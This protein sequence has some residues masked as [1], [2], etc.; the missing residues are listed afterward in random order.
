MLIRLPVRLALAALVL[1]A[2]AFLLD[3]AEGSVVFN[4]LGYSFSTRPG[5]LLACL[6]AMMLALI[7]IGASLARIRG[8]PQKWRAKRAI[9]TMERLLAAAVQAIAAKA[10]DDPKNF[11]RAAARARWISPKADLTQLLEA[12]R[13]ASR[14]KWKKL[15][16]NRQLSLSAR[17][18]LGNLALANRRV[19]LA[20]DYAEDAGDEDPQWSSSVTAICAA[21]EGDWQAAEAPAKKSK[22]PTLRATISTQRSLNAS[23]D[24]AVEFAKRALAHKADFIPAALRLCQL[25]PADEADRIIAKVW[26]IRPHPSLLRVAS[27]QLTEKLARLHPSNPLSQTAAAL[28]ALSRNEVE[29]AERILAP[30]SDS[31]SAA[32]RA[33]ERVYRQ[34]GKTTK[35]DEIGA[36]TLVANYLKCKKCDAMAAEWQAICRQCGGFASMD[37]R[38]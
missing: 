19:T 28:S 3:T 26:K 37:W 4:W 13:S 27:E 29:E 7:V 20:A 10:A 9:S 38:Y 17:R 25:L 24:E 34:Q 22:D 30:I 15:L 8:L 5:F 32:A 35:A 12:Y 11:E 33:M 2:L 6:L 14:K 16:Q 21:L 18:Y 1:F 23:G 31:S 36:T